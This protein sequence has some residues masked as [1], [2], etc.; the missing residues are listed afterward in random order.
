MRDPQTGD[1]EPC[2]T[3]LDK[4]SPGGLYLRTMF[5][6]AGIVVIGLLVFFCIKLLNA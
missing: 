2:S 1:L 5:I 4:A 3:C 6:A